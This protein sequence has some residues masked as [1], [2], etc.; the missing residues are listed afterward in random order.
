MKK[1]YIMK[2]LMIAL[3]FLAFAISSCDNDKDFEPEA[4]IQGE[5]EIVKVSTGLNGE[6]TANEI[7]FQEQYIFHKNGSFVK[8][9]Q[10][11]E[12][13]FE[14]SGEYSLQEVDPTDSSRARMLLTLEYTTEP[15]RAWICSEE[16]EEFILTHDG[17]LYKTCMGLMDGPVYY[18]EK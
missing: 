3:A 13:S 11:E 14:I 8:K 2:K 18:F 5:W 16:T 7:D 17:E 4:A 15:N 12:E 10:S 9:H 1:Q 6:L